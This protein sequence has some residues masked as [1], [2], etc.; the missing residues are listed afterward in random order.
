MV[1]LERFSLPSVPCLLVVGV[2]ADD[3]NPLATG[4]LSRRSGFFQASPLFLRRIYGV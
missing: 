3:W 2:V 4:S 1:G